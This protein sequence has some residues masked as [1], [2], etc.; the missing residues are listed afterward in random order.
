MTHIIGRTL[1]EQKYFY[2]IEGTVF[3]DKGYSE[4][5]ALFVH[6]IVIGRVECMGN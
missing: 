2:L 5:L 4:K 1:S 6:R 3:H